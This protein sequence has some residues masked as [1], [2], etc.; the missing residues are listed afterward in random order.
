[1]LPWP[2]H[3]ALVGVSDTLANEKSMSDQ[4]QRLFNSVLMFIAR[5][6]SPPVLPQQGTNIFILIKKQITVA[7]SPFKPYQPATLQYEYNNPSGGQLFMEGQVC[8]DLRETK[9]GNPYPEERSPG[10]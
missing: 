5:W 8:W 7:G 10:Q 6:L 1:M 4:T 9:G 2:T 3:R